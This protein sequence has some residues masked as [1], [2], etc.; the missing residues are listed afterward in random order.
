MLNKFG[1]T[2]GRK[3]ILCLNLV[4]TIEL[5][6]YCLILS[7]Y[8]GNKTDWK[9]TEMS[10]N[11]TCEVN[12]VVVLLLHVHIIPVMKED[13]KVMPVKKISSGCNCFSWYWRSSTSLI[14]TSITDFKS[15][16]IVKVIGRKS[17][18]RYPWGKL[19][20]FMLFHNSKDYSKVHSYWPFKNCFLNRLYVLE[21]F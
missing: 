8:I 20:N 19:L 3:Q 2:I 21:K 13:I 15:S 14:A 10:L 4:K 9:N 5:L 6:Y 1:V 18:D 17:Y 7:C 12:F 16:L 11:C